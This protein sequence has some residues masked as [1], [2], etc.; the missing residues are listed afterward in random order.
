MIQLLEQMQNQILNK[1]NSSSTLSYSHISNN[2]QSKVDPQISDYGRSISPIQSTKPKRFEFLKSHFRQKK[3]GTIPAGNISLPIVNFDYPIYSSRSLP[4]VINQKE[5]ML[6]LKNIELE[7]EED[8]MERTRE[9]QRR[10]FHRRRG[11]VATELDRM[12]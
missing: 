2:W 12:N 4:R 8:K 7:E 11:D 9:W 6:N 1:F 5:E 10:E 3:L